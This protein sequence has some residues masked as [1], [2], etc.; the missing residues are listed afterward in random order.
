MSSDEEDLE[1]LALLRERLGL[2]PAS[3]DAP[4]E[5][6]VLKSSEYIYDHSVDVSIVSR[7]TKAAASSLW[8]TMKEKNISTLTWSDHELHPKSKDES[9]LNF[10]FTMDLLNFSFWSELS[11]DDRFQVLYREKKW[12]GYWSLVAIMQRALE[13]GESRLLGA[14]WTKAYHW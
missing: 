8:E 13:E 5:T 14:C 12:T 4:P 11:E 7:S 6:G 10:I 3:K 2:G 9:T 1:L